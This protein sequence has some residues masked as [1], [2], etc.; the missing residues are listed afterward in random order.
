MKRMLRVRILFSNRVG[1]GDQVQEHV[2][3]RLM[4]SFSTEAQ[5]LPLETFL[6]DLCVSVVRNLYYQT[7]AFFRRRSLV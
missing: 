5:R 4:L 1:R 6:C 3:N 7:V 2:Q